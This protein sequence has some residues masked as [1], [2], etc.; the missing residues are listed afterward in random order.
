MELFSFSSP[1]AMTRLPP[2]SWRRAGMEKPTSFSGQSLTLPIKTRGL[3]DA[4]NPQLLGFRPQASGSVQGAASASSSTAD[5]GKLEMLSKDAN[6]VFVAGATGRVGSRTV[7][8]LLRLGFRVRAGVRSAQKAETLVQSVRQMKLDDGAGTSGAQP[9]EKLEI[10]D[11]DLENQGEI[12]PAIGNSSIVVCC[13]GASEKEVFDV[14]GPYRIDYKATKNLIEAATSAKVDHFILLTSLGTNKIGFPASILNLF[15]GVLIWKRKAEEALLASGLPYTVV[16]PGGMER[17]TDSYKETHNIVL[18]N[19]DT[20]FA[21]QVSNLQVAEL[22]AFMAKNRKLSFCKVVEVIAET[23]APLLLMEELLAKIPP[24]RVGT[25]SKELPAELKQD[26]TAPRITSEPTKSVIKE[27]PKQMEMPKISPL[28]PYSMY[29]DLRPPTSPTPTPSTT[30]GSTKEKQAE[31]VQA[32]MEPKL[33]SLETSSSVSRGVTK[34]EPAQAP[35]QK[36][37]ALSPYMAYKDLK[38]PTSPT[39]T[40]SSG[41]LRPKE[42]MV[43]ATP[44]SVPQ[45][46]RHQSPYPVS[47]PPIS[48]SP[49][50]SAAVSSVSASANDGNPLTSTSSISQTLTANVSAEAQHVKQQKEQA[51]SPFT[52]Y[53]DLK[54]PSSPI[55]DD[56][57]ASEEHY[58]WF[59]DYSQFRHL[60]H[61]LLNP[62]LSVLEV[63]CGNSRLCEDLFQDGVTDITCIDLSSVAVDR[64]RK[65]LTD[66]GVHGIKV[67][68]ADMLDLP[69]SSEC[70]DLVIEKGTMVS[71]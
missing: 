16:R 68:Q 41:L 27:E 2:S 46:A 7:R 8:E 45:N 63:G 38:P 55:P 33:T 13:I 48:P 51:L 62:A 29:E 11:C 21:G 23:T 71:H 37:R 1:A 52:M 31:S 3:P 14:T 35:T 5:S 50:A 34:S 69:F 65:R 25:S 36:T 32:K 66:Q 64:M 19:E 70:F 26:P 53:E 6:L 15:W 67:L 56:R 47:G 18:A 54:P 44:S 58:E 12:S 57:F 39:P 60:L 10:V 9:V 40:P 4:P 42:N 43:N 30:T 24:Q 28:S 49:N 20:L 61:P 22:M 17:P 59:K